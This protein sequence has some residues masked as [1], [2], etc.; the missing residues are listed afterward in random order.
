MLDRRT[1]ERTAIWSLNGHVEIPQVVFMRSSRDSRR[2]VCH[3][4]LR[5]LSCGGG[6]LRAEEECSGPHTLIIRCD[7][8]S[9]KARYIGGLQRD[10]PSEEPWHESKRSEDTVAGP[11]ESASVRSPTAIPEP[12]VNSDYLLMSDTRSL[13]ESCRPHRRIMQ[14]RMTGFV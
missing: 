2:R 7:G 4:T 13:S 12:L 8:A 1:L 14:A 5:F 9:V 6:G 3:Q 10:T 11:H